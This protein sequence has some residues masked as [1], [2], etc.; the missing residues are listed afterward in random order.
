M[1][2]LRH[3]LDGIDGRVD[4]EERIADYARF[5]VDLQVVSTVPVMFCYWAPGGQAL[6]LHRT[7]NDHSAEICREH[8]KHYLGLGTVPLQ[9]P[10]VQNAM[11]GYVRPGG[12]WFREPVIPCGRDWALVPSAF[13]TLPLCH[14]WTTPPPENR[15]GRRLL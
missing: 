3:V 9:E 6:E 8:P 5:N 10:Q 13:P 15:T 1:Q 4:A 11:G 7:L 2:Q 14:A 12:Q